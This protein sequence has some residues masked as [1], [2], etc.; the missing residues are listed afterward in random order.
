MG[1]IQGGPFGPAFYPQGS[2]HL[3]HLQVK[4]SAQGQ[5]P[6]IA[7]KPPSVGYPGQQPPYGHYVHGQGVVPPNPYDFN[8]SAVPHPYHQMNG[9][10]PA[11]SS[12]PYARAQSD[13][14]QHHADPALNRQRGVPYPS[15]SQPDPLAMKREGM[16]MKVTVHDYDIEYDDFEMPEDDASMGESDD[17][18]QDPRQVLGPVM[19][20][21][22][23]TWDTNGTR[24][25]TFSTFAQSNILS[26]YTASARITELKDPVMLQIFMH[27]IQVTG[28]SMSLYER[29]PFD[30][31]GENSFDPT[32]KGA[33]N[34]WSCKSHIFPCRVHG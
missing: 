3:G 23:G 6:T 34:L 1:T 21:F 29:H 16:Q 9:M 15:D 25:R 19:K 5:L 20:Q 17:D 32:P 11:D 28:P 10:M 24:V 27:F 14:R 30:H 8:A 7:P 26:D 13:P 31:T 2:A 33:N 18:T 22:N 12:M 4:A